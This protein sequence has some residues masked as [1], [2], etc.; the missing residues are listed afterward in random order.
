[1]CVCACLSEDSRHRVVDGGRGSAGARPA[2]ARATRT[3]PCHALPDR[4]VP[5]RAGHRQRVQCTPQAPAARL[6][7]K[8]EPP[9]VIG[10]FLFGKISNNALADC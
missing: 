2:R 9:H 7:Q 6:G 3:D 10:C 1:M 8:N 5:G 4:A